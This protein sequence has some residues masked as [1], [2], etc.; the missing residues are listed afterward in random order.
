MFVVYAIRSLAT[1]KIYIGQTNDLAT[2]L[3]QHNSG[4]VLSTRNHRPWE[5]IK[6]EKFETRHQA[7]WFEFQLKKSRGRRIKWL[8]K[9]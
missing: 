7:R 3:A 4:K 5:A 1:A 8:K 6:T 9:K 2:R